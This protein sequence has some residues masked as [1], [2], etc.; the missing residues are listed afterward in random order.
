MSHV[1]PTLRLLLDY[2][3]EIGCVKHCN[4]PFQEQ[5]AASVETYCAE[6]D[7]AVC[8]LTLQELSELIK[9][10]TAKFNGGAA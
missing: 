6:E 1:S 5:L 2:S 9:T 8:A 7:K 4:G 3:A 10:E